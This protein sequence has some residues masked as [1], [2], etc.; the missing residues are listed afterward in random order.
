MADESSLHDHAVIAYI[1]LLKKTLLNTIYE[2]PIIQ[3][4]AM[5]RWK[6]RLVKRLLGDETQ[7]FRIEHF[8]VEKRQG[9]LD[10]PAVAHSMIG[11]KR[12]NNLYECLSQVIRDDVPGDFIE[13]GVWRG[14]ASIFAKGVFNVLGQHSRRVWVA[15]SFEGLPKPNPDDYPEDANDEHY[16]LDFLKVGLE[17]VK[18]NFSKYDLLDDQVCFVKG[19]FK[20]TLPSLPIQSISVL[21]LDGDMYEST[22]VALESLYHKLSHLGYIIIDDYCIRSCAQAVADFRKEHSI[23]EPIQEIDGI[24]IFWRKGTGEED[25]L[26]LAGS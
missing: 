10:W 25:A 24:G 1:E 6:S 17:D 18:A 21:R 20:D 12:M 2:D 23:L 26:K 4:V 13:T 16:K 22:I 14:G 15:D 7:V 3:Q 19:W 8:D 11:V 5:P 9:G